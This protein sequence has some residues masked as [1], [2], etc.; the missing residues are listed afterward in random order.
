MVVVYMS[1]DIIGRYTYNLLNPI[2]NNK[3]LDMTKLKAFADDEVNIDKM[4]I[5]LLDKVENTEGK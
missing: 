2:P 4:T 3:I 5:F 1:L